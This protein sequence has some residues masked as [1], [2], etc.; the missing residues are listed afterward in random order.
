MKFEMTMMAQRYEYLKDFYNE[1]RL[2]ETKKYSD[3]TGEYVNFEIE[4]DSPF[5]IIEIFSAGVKYGINGI[6][7]SNK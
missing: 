5:D 1:K 3:A 7:L 6:N 2:T 4:V